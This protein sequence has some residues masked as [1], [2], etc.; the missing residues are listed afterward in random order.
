[1]HERSIQEEFR[2]ADRDVAVDEVCLKRDL[3]I[4]ELL[5][6]FIMHCQEAQQIGAEARAAAGIGRA[7]LSSC[8]SGPSELERIEALFRGSEAAA[9]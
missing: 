6:S 7:E 9:G 1:M 5:S 3:S 4:D 8:G 2:E